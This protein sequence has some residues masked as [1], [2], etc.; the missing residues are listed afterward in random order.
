MTNY[1]LKNF[2]ENGI[3]FPFAVSNLINSNTETKYFDFQNTAEKIFGRQITLK[4][5]LISKFFDSICFNEE[6]INNVKKIIGP[7]I[8]IWSSAIFA[9]APGSGKVVSFHQDNPYWQLTTENVVTAWVALTNSNSESGALQIVPR[10]HKLGLLKKLDVEDARAAYV[11]GLKTTEANDMLSYKQDLND[12]LLKNKP[13][14]ISLKPGEYSIHHVNTV[15]GSAQ[16][17]SKNYRIGFAI[18]YISSDTQHEK[19][20]KDYGL[21]VCGD[22]NPYFID[23]KRP[24]GDFVK[25]EVALYQ[26]SMSSGGAFGNKKY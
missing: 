8:Y 23:E 13:I 21:H 25:E 16:N 22:K 1:N 11:K 10:S 12:F 4:P 9:K 20:T 3:S 15:H 14:T 7:N 6:I 26:A 18:R 19:L 2:K 17:Q 5:N 24:S